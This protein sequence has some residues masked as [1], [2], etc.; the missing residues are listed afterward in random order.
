[1]QPFLTATRLPVVLVSFHQ[2]S[3]VDE[4]VEQTPWALAPAAR[5]SQSLNSM[6]QL[7]SGTRAPVLVSSLAWKLM[8]LFWAAEAVGVR[9]LFPRVYRP[10]VRIDKPKTVVT[11]KKTGTTKRAWVRFRN[12]CFRYTEIPSNVF[13]C[14]FLFTQRIW[15]LRFFIVFEICFSCVLFLQLCRYFELITDKK[16]VIKNTIFKGYPHL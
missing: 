4:L 5:E 3:S 10:G 12:S 9:G 13:V 7:P 1:M 8:V 6:W 14:F 16:Q 11:N 2:Q 15:F